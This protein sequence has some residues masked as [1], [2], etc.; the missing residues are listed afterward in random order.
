VEY[1]ALELI[2]KLIA[3]WNCW[4]SQEEYYL[5]VLAPDIVRGSAQLTYKE[6]EM[7]SE[8]R[9]M[10]TAEE[11]AQLPELI[12]ECRAGRL[13]ELASD[14]EREQ[15][16]K[17][18]ERKE[19]EHKEEQR[20]LEEKR[21]R[22]IL[23]ETRRAKAKEAKKRA[24]LE[25]EEEAR[26][27]RKKA[28]LTRLKS[29][30]ESDFLSADAVLAADPDAGLISGDEYE[31]IKTRFVWAWTN[32][33]LLPSLDSEQAAAVATMKGNVLVV[34]RAGSGKTRTLI[35][36]AIFLQKHCGVLPC[37]LLL[38]AF[39]QEAA[40]EMKNRLTKTLGEHLPH[41]MTFH[42]LAHALVHPKEELVYDNPSAE[43]F[44]VSSEVQEVI[45][46]H[47]R[48]EEYR[49]RIQ[50]LMLAHF[51][52]DWECIVNGCFQLTMGE[53]LAHRRELPRKSLKGD[54]VKSFGEKVIANILFEYGVEYRY[55]R[56]F[57]WNGVNYRPDFTIPV[58]SKGGVI[59][60]YFGLKEDADYDKMSQQKRRFWAKRDEWTFIEFSPTD[61]AQNGVKDFVDALL[62]R[63]RTA[64][65]TCRR[66]SEEEIWELIRKR[67]LD[68]FTEAMKTFVSRC[69]KRNLDYNALEVLVNGHSPCSTAES[70]FLDVGTSVY[71]GYLERLAAYKKED[72]DGLIW[73]SVSLVR[74]GQTRFVRDKGRERGDVTKLRFVM[75]DE[76]QDFSKMFFKLVDAIRSANPQVQFFCVGDDWQAINAFAGSD[77]VFFDNFNRYF[78][79]ISQR[80]IRTNYRSSTA[81]IETGNALMYG[82]GPAAEPKGTDVGLVQL[83]KLDEFKPSALEQARHN[84]DELTPAVLRLVKSFLDRGL[85]VVM[86]S[87]RNDLP[88][89]VS[90]GKAT[91]GVPDALMRFQEH[92]HSYLPEEDRKRVTAS[93]THK[94]KGL[95]RSAV[96]VLD[97]VGSSYPLIH[98]NWV[99]LRVFGDSIDHIID[100][101]RRLFYVAA[102]RAKDSLALVTETFTESPFL[103][104]IRRQVSLESIS[105]D[106]LCPVLSLDGDLLEIRVFNA[107]DVKD[108][109]KHLKYRWNSTEKYW[110]KAVLAEEFSIDILLEQLGVG[111][112]VSVEVWSETGEL[113]LRI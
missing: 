17:E 14:C 38:L 7:I 37:E 5:T 15:V 23:I 96:I 98:P 71:R 55:E 76:F 42:A 8:L 33:G 105:W 34:A 21:K 48:S 36:R 81:I 83:C 9:G 108:Q 59:I 65:V 112:R 88:W 39:N 107:Y 95:E 94:F 1:T 28:L 63:L 18:A 99:F 100:E 46:E 40:K 86:L 26:E 80:Y 102:T 106:R 53:F 101:E 73:R 87:R 58:K 74:D 6:R 27:V 89:Y 50:H 75:I 79:N 44:G 41:V 13:K 16:R 12:T 43:V 2:K 113:L 61:I 85:D 109:L 77:L 91:G 67:A 35:T 93:T 72:F 10:L 66:R 82:R 62:Q 49:E 69:R 51:R 29:V 30:L 11:W 25:A 19:A 111:D 45:D 110:H 97:A 60:E 54:Y 24:K 78:Q 103:D 104:A 57:R 70:L 92:I 68:S 20:I 64:G 32:R 47:M 3:C 4:D 31:S 22:Q 56:A 52:E 90:Y 84:G